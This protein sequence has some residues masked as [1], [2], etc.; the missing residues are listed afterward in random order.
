MRA[1]WPL[2]LG[3]MVAAI[4]VEIAT[5]QDKAIFALNWIPSG[6]HFGVF[7]AQQ[8]GFF[9][10]ANLQVDIQRGYGSGDTLKRVAIGTADIGIADA[11]SVIIG[12]TNGLKVKQVASIFDTAFDCIFFLE[13]NGI[14]QPKDLE[15]RSLGAA[16]S[17]TTVNILPIFAA[18][19]GVDL[20]KISILSISPSAKYASLAARTVDS[21]VGSTVE[22]P[23]NQNAAQKIGSKV[24]RFRFSDYGVDYYSIG[25]VTSDEMLA[26]RPDL[27]RR[28]VAATMQGYAW[29]IQHPDEAAEAFA[30]SVP[31][32]SRDLMLAQWKITVGHMITERT[33]SNGLGWIDRTRMI[34]TLELTKTYQNVDPAIRIEDLYTME[35][36]P[37]IP[38]N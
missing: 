10:N 20:K 28:L 26:K 17:E 3:V 7:A 22:E 15:G 33:R 23:A 13:G 37:K 35:Y 27:V 1:I 24:N 16:P 8:Q 38:V 31:E 12:R 11:A 34:N 32:S 19:T 6:N 4:A 9:R 21:I 2:I 5:A 14:T 29:S 36:L 25:L 30:K 18:K